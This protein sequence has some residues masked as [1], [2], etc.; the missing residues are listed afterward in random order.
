MAA[1]LMKMK[2]KMYL[3]VDIV[4]PKEYWLSVL[5]LL[6]L[7][8]SIDPAPDILLAPPPPVPVRPAGV[9]LIP[10][11][12]S[13]TTGA[14]PG[15]LLWAGPPPVKL[16]PP[17]GWAWLGPAT[18]WWEDGICWWPPWKKREKWHWIKEG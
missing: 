8:D 16:T 15:A 17:P 6:E 9:K 10:G 1:Y 2:K 18:M 12:G 3:P 4:D 13:E 5:L 14:G 11:T 7:S